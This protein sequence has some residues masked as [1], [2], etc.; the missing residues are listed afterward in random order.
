VPFADAQLRMVLQVKEWL[1]Q[2]TDAVVMF[3]PKLRHA[4][5]LLDIPWQ[6]QIL[7]QLLPLLDNKLQQP[8]QQL[9]ATGLLFPAHTWPRSQLY[10]IGDADE[11]SF[12][13]GGQCDIWQHQG[14]LQQQP[15]TP[16]TYMQQQQLAPGSSRATSSR[17]SSAELTGVEAVQPG[18]G[19]PGDFTAAAARSSAPAVSQSDN[20]DD[21]DDDDDDD[22]CSSSSVYESMYTETSSMSSSRASLQMDNVGQQHG[23]FTAAA[24]S[25]SLADSGRSAAA[26]AA[27]P[28]GSEQGSTAG[29]GDTWIGAG[30]SSSTG[31]SS[32]DGSS[33]DGSAYPQQQHQ[34]RGCDS[35]GSV[36][37]ALLLPPRLQAAPSLACE[38]QSVDADSAHDLP[39]PGML[40]PHVSLASLCSSRTS[41]GNSSHHMLSASANDLCQGGS[42]AS[43]FAAAA[44][45]AGGFS[46]QQQLPQAPSLQIQPLESWTGVVASAPASCCAGVTPDGS[47]AA[48]AA[49]ELESPRTF[50]SGCSSHSWQDLAALA[51]AREAATAAHILLQPVQAL[52]RL[53]QASQRERKPDFQQQQ[54]QQ[55]D[56]RQ[57]LLQQQVKLQHQQRDQGEGEAAGVVSQ[58]QAVSKK[59]DSMLRRVELLLHCRPNRRIGAAARA[60]NSG[61]GPSPRSNGAGSFAR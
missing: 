7:K 59:R 29:C 32:A 11:E 56:Q 21:D 2:R 12:A 28:A 27:E 23:H 22:D 37:A 39:A 47:S 48:S 58:Q 57:Q 20:A 49:A 53:R 54:Q 35:K 60:A 8:Q 44:A 4:G 52:K 16:Q 5:F 18:F 31:S 34:I 36:V 33:V 13:A 42:L 24:P 1:E 45:T 6:Q 14:A 30:S 51:A 15:T 40:A 46:R 43:P 41:N 17:H 50:F 10:G 19:A 55:Y 26:A 3:H 61:G 25:G 9:P 38:L